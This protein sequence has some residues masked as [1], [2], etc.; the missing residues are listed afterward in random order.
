MLRRLS[1]GIC[2]TVFLIL[3]AVPALADTGTYG[4]SSY[5]VTLIPRDDGRVVISIEQTWNVHSGSIPWVTVGLPNSHFEIESSSGAADRI[6]KETSGGF[7]GVRIDLDKDYQP[8]ESFDV[9]FT[10]LQNNLL[11][12]LPDEEI[13]RIRYTPGWYDRATIDS[14]TIKLISPVHTDSYA[15]LKPTPADISGNTITW[16]RS[17]LSPGSKFEITVESVD[18]RFL[19]EGAGIIAADGGQ[20]NTANGVYVLVGILVVI[21]LLVGVLVWDKRRKAR[22]R[23]H[24]EI[25]RIEAEMAKDEKKKEEIEEGFKEYVEEENLQPDEEGKYY[26]KKHGYVTPA[27][28][29]AVISNQYRVYH[30]YVGP[31]MH[32][33]T[34]YRPSCVSCACVSCACACACAC[35]GGGAAGCSRKTL[36]ECP[37][38]RER[39]KKT[40]N[41]DYRPTQTAR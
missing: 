21:G 1:A 31:H 13:W 26:D 34:G 24:N 35:A 27:I 37:A 3:A 10:V 23:T 18:G 25:M 16:E 33:G 22:A 32:S 17:N 28:W 11:E 36:H 8:G 19:K 38:C 6:R 5:N 39:E 20:D 30:P 29:A 40:E 9:R 14:M 12:R 7:T 2:V 4:I 15:T 41:I